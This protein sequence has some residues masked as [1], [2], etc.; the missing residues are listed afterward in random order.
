M[1]VWDFYS[2]FVRVHTVARETYNVLFSIKFKVIVVMNFILIT[3]VFFSN[4]PLFCF[5]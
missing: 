2:L 3:L 4:F 1:F 5:E